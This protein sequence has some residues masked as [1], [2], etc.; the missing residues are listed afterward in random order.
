[1]MK[2]LALGFHDVIEPGSPEASGFPGP[3]A[4]HYKVDASVF[5]AYLEAMARG[6][7]TPPES[8]PAF[9]AGTAVPF[10]LTFDDGGA[11]ALRTADM[12]DR[13]GW[14]GYFLVTTNFIGSAGFLTGGEIRQVRQRGHVIG[15]HSCSHPSR[16]SALSAAEMDAEWKGS[17]ETLSSL[18]G[19]SVT[20]ASVPGGYLSRD[21]ARSAARAGIRLLFTSEPTTRV[22]TVDACA[23]VGR[24]AVVRGTPV[25]VATALASGDAAPRW[26][27]SLLWNAKKGAK[28]LGGKHYLTL[29]RFIFSRTEGA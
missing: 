14:K 12:L 16:M 26:R 24:Y 17:V 20:V 29:R 28:M 9:P 7:R 13:F 15:S 5:A 11:S 6:L 27:Q 1:M 25:S 23:V 8:A 21:V 10:Y 4:G 19:E 2:A 18:L 3:A 22:E